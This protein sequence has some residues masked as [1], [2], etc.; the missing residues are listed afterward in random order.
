M[1][2]S[3]IN[4]RGKQLGIFLTDLGESE[5]NQVKRRTLMNERRPYTLD[6]IASAL[7]IFMFILALVLDQ[8]GLP[9]LKYIGV[10]VLAIGLILAFLPMFSLRKYGQTAEG[11]NYMHTVVVVD[12]GIYAVVRHPQYLGYMLLCAGFIGINQHWI[13][14]IVGLLAMLFFYLHT[15]QE[16]RYCSEIFGETY[17]KYMHK[18]PRFNILLGL[19]HWYR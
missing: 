7:M 10:L 17:Q 13:I 6:W 12:Q 19:I 4:Y 9:L 11:E 18:V 5:Y 2:G 15:L 14:I 1:I 16:E 8:D 3:Q